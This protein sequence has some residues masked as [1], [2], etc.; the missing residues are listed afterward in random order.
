VVGR[1]I[2]GGFTLIELMIS[3]LVSSLLVAMIITVYISMSQGYRAQ[4]Q[5]AEVQQILGAAQEVITGDLRQVGL[6]L[7]QGFNWVGATTQPVPALSIVDGAANPD[8]L[9][10]FYADPTAQARITALASP[11]T[12][13]TVDSVDRFV[14]GDLAV[15]SLAQ[16]IDSSLV[17]YEA[18]ATRPPEEPTPGDLSQ[19]AKTP[20]FYACAVKITAITGNVLS[21]S[22]AAPWGNATN[23]ECDRV[24]AKFNSA[25]G[26]GE[27]RVF[28]IYR[29]VAHAYRIDTTRPDLGVLQMSAS[30]GLVA[31]DWQD[32]G[33]GFTDLQIASRWYDSQLG[34][35]NADTGTD[36]RRNW[37]SGAEQ[38]TRA[39]ASAPLTPPTNPTD[40][41]AALKVSVSLVARTTRDVIG[42]TVTAATPVLTDTANVNYNE[43]GNHGAVQLEGVADTSRPAALRGN[44]IYRYTTFKVDVRNLGTGR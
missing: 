6:A 33:V 13:V 34:V 44:R 39:I 18:G 43:L 19:Q 40:S 1:A 16:I 35:D 7:P 12:T 11:L 2:E 14:I 37:Y 22:T 27:T 4:Q 36:P 20:I 3:L 8:Q 26:V 17:A 28:M 29:F 10:L 38:A 30:G 5:V 24:V 31:N 41:V 32:L 25:P 15:I 9:N 21:L 23:S 42:G